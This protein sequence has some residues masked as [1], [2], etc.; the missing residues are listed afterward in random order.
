MIATSF[1]SPP[2]VPTIHQELL[3]SDADARDVGVVSP[4]DA[5][6]AA[7]RIFTL[8]AP[9]GLVA[10]T[11]LSPSCHCVSAALLAVG[12]AESLPRTLASGGPLSVA[13]SVALSELRP[14]PF[15]KTVVVY[16]RPPGGGAE[17][18][19]ARLIVRGTLLPAVAVAA[20]SSAPAAP[21]LAVLPLG[22]L[23]LA[24]P[25]DTA[26]VVLVATPDPR[27][28]R[29][30]AVVPPLASA[31]PGVRAE[32]L[33]DA[34]NGALRY[35]VTAAPDAPIGPVL[36]M[37]AFAPP[38]SDRSVRAAAWRSAGIVVTGEVVGDIATSPRV[39][40][41]GVAPGAGATPA[42]GLAA[43]KAG[44][45]VPSSLSRAVTLTAR[46]AKSF[47]R[48]TVTRAWKK[49]PFSPA[50]LL[51]PATGAG[52]TA[53]ERTLLI[54]LAPDAARRVAAGEN[55]GFFQARVT[56]RLANGQRLV[57]PVSAF[58]Q[59]GLI[60][61]APAPARQEVTPAAPKP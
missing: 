40:A 35:R 4:L 55:G 41:F 36:G 29:D 34:K 6:P 1:Q 28:A 43:P 33:P 46:D 23:D 59:Q 58:L 8:R 22:T 5:A 24:A 30:H 12:V 52:A 42:P 53:T 48:R 20:G 3:V 56:V 10:V 16:A 14:G 15:T 26:G 18:A 13:V 7:A 38:V 50:R 47:A 39:V 25:P 17:F 54:T 2:A 61:A 45:T 60:P 11:R 57:L 27:L 19:L 32:R 44:D 31:I 9:V 37:L 51:P 49:P 21:N